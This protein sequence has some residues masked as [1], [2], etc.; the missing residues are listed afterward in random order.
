MWKDLIYQGKNYGYKFEISDRGSLRNK[1]T[2]TVYKLNVTTNGYL[3]VVVS[4]GNKKI[5]NFR[6]HKAVAETFI[7]NP[8]NKPEVNHIDGNKQNNYVENLEW[9]TGSE[10]VQHAYNMGLASAKSHQGENSSTNKLT[11]EDVLY[12]KTNYK[13]RHPEFGCRALARKFGVHHKLIEMIIHNER[14]KHI[15]MP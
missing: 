6:I 15:I 12:I 11:D 7:P 10:N 13:P 2:G 5:K 3:D 14:W 4:L 1:I 9:V 8:K